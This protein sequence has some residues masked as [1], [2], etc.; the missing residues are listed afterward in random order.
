MYKQVK[1]PKDNKSRVVA[2]SVVQKKNSVRQV[3][4]FIDNRP[5]SNA[6]T[7]LQKKSTG[8]EPMCGCSS[9]SG[10]IQRK[11]KDESS[12]DEYSISQLHQP[13][14]KSLTL[15]VIQFGRRFRA[16]GYNKALKGKS[17]SKAVTIASGVTTA[18]MKLSKNDKIVKTVNTNSGGNY[19]APQWIWNRLKNS[20]AGRKRKADAEVKALGALTPYIETQEDMEGWKLSVHTSIDI[21]RF[22]K[23]HIREW[24]NY[25]GVTWDN[26]PR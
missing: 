25:Y 2:N 21:C 1:K 19:R 16:K 22:C 26:D 9:C 14:S 12:I 4:S 8:H 5:K 18:T 17:A 13:Q 3:F 15:N 23:G 20:A 7:I 24:C 6:E 11:S 10:T